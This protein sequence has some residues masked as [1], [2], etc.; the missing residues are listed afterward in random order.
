MTADEHLGEEFTDQQSA[1]EAWGEVGTQFEALGESLSQALRAG[2]ESEETQ[3]HVRSMQ[4]GL[5]RMVKRID[6]AVKEAGESERAQRV[7]QEAERAADS[8]RDAG[9]K[10]WE[11]MRPQVISG[12]RRVNAELR[13]LID[14]LERRP[15]DQADAS[16]RDATTEATEAAD[17]QPVSTYESGT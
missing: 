17:A 11:D 12:L 7:R 4:E 9:E 5:E 3:R 2:W 1:E 14:S 10:T 8:L 15:V 16:K 13:R 6:R